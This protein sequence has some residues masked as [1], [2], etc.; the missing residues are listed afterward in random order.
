MVFQDDIL[1]PAE[2]TSNGSHQVAG[3]IISAA[4]DGVKV[5]NLSDPVVIEFSPTKVRFKN[6]LIFKQICH[7]FSYFVLQIDAICNSPLFFH[8]FLCICAICIRS[9]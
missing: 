4:I 7:T 6:G 3:A 2:K 8:F 1:F 9:L 5:Q